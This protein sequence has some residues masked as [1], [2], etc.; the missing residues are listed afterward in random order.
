MGDAQ[1]ELRAYLVDLER[2][3]ALWQRDAATARGWAGFS[4]EAYTA[5]RSVAW[6]RYVGAL[7]SGP[8]L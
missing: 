2:L 5:R 4:E 6:D 7:L 8:R 3:F 1:Q